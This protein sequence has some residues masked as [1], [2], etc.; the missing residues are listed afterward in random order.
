MDEA[1]N[2]TVLLFDFDGT[3]ADILSVIVDI[4]N[5]IGTQYNLRKIDSEKLKI[6]RNMNSREL[7][8]Y[9]GLPLRKIP[10]FIRRVQSEMKHRMKDIEPFPN[11]PDVL[12]IINKKG[13]QL[14]ILTSN[15]KDNVK[16][17]LE[18][19]DLSYFEDIF[20]SRNISGKKRVLEK[21]IKYK[22]LNRESIIYFG[23]EIRDIEAAKDAKIKIAA[24]TWGFNDEESLKINNPDFLINKPEEIVNLLNI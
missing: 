10:F 4:I 23:D 6:I 16:E 24:V 17:F 7:I 8:K 1:R 14:N 9:S 13:F 22:K 18:K 12:K 20:V 15:L 19:N 21:I 3:L 5:D 11:I 2:K